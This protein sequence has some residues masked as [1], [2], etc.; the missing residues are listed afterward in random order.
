MARLISKESAFA[1]ASQWGSFMHAGDPGAC[2][3]GFHHNDGR[4]VS[5]AHRLDCL[6]WLRARR[7]DTAID[8]QQLVQLIRFIAYTPLFS[9][10]G[11]DSAPAR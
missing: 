2:M 3:Y 7:A 5:E 10:A 8:E 9:I 4:P 6:R 1:F 11:R